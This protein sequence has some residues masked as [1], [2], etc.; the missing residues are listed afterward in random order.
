MPSSGACGCG[1][2]HDKNAPA[3]PG[4]E[5]MS[6]QTAVERVCNMMLLTQPAWHCIHADWLNRHEPPR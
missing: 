4:M 1:G 6:L 2:A 3:K 5:P